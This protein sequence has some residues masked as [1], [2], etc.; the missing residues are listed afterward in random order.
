MGMA[1]SIEGR[2]PFLDYRL[3][4]VCNRLPPRLK[5][6]GLMDF[7]KQKTAYEITYGDWSSACALPIYSGARI[8]RQRPA[9]VR[10]TEDRRAAPHHRR[11]VAPTAARGIGRPPA[12]PHGR[13][14][15]I[16]VDQFVGC[17]GCM[18]G[19]SFGLSRTTSSLPPLALLPI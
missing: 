12:R 17:I 5:L 18:I 3:V 14:H 8:A 1:H 4:E 2:F 15:A 7:F 19:L 11:N 16:E 9:V 13:A 6:R 10:R